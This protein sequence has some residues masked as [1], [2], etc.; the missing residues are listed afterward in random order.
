ML[1]KN[2]VIVLFYIKH[3]EHIDNNKLYISLLSFQKN[4][5]IL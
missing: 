3:Y 5:I 1:S 2:Y 4:R